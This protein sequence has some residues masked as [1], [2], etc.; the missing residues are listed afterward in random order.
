MLYEAFKKVIDFLYLDDIGVL[1]GIGDS[2]EMIEIIRLA[3]QFKIAELFRAAEL[4]FQETM[5]AWFE[6]NSVFSLRPPPAEKP[7]QNSKSPTSVVGA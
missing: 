2:S 3:R 7:T 1:Q 4:H 6:S 5:F